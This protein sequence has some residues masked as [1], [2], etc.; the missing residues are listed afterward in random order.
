[1][2]KRN[3]PIS[4]LVIAVFFL[5]L[6]MI[7]VYASAANAITPQ[8]AFE[9]SSAKESTSVSSGNAV[10]LRAGECVIETIDDEMYVGKAIHLS[11]FENFVIVEDVRYPYAVIGL[12]IPSTRIKKIYTVSEIK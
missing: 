10:V 6:S 2:R 9:E 11:S 8:R 5:A 1:M 7:M 3:N 4:Y 12:M